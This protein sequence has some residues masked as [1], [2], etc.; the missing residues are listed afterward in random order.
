MFY[1]SGRAVLTTSDSES[2]IGDSDIGSPRRQSS[3]EPQVFKVAV[4][5]SPSLPDR[6][7]AHKS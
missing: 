1:C 2:D 4:S 6:A 5:P 3:S 7:G